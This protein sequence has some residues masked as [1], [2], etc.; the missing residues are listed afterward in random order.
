MSEIGH[1]KIWQKGHPC[2]VTKCCTWGRDGFY[3]G[4]GAKADIILKFCRIRIGFQD[5]A[6]FFFSFGKLL[7][8]EIWYFQGPVLGSS[9][10]V[11]K[12][13]SVKMSPVIGT[14]PLN[15]QGMFFGIEV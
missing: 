15:S 9:K 5:Q 14:E 4:S 2:D 6:V 13:W 8:N 11:L 10:K 12:C 1:V 3:S 7:E